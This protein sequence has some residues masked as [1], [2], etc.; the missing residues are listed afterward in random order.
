MTF[1]QLML[2]LTA[3]GTLLTAIATVGLVVGAIMAWQV[4]KANL[5]HLRD[6]SRAQT[7]P[8]V[9]AQLVP[10]I[11]GAPTWDL[12]VRNSGRSSAKN[13][14]IDV[15]AWPETDDVIVALKNLFETPQ[16]LPPGTSIRTFWSLGKRHDPQSTGA[17]GIDIPVDLTVRYGSDDPDAPNYTETF[18]ID[19][20][21]IGPT[22]VAHSGIEL[23]P[24]ATPTEKKLK[25]IVLALNELRRGL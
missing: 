9:Y 4:A 7:R 17:T 6:D 14:Q 20:E 15:S 13:L 1:E 5:R 18:R 10:G 21:G 25:E 8:Y 24:N 11:A 12:I 3:V 22:P 2:L 23:P 16:T 19:S